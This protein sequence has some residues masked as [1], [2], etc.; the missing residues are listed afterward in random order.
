MKTALFTAFIAL[1]FAQASQAEIRIG[2]DQEYISLM[3][4]PTQV[5]P[6][7]GLSVTVSEGGLA[8]LSKITV[9]RHFLGHSTEEKFYTKRSSPTRMGEATS[10][11][12][13]GI[14]LTVNFTTAPR[15]DGGAYSTLQIKKNGVT[16]MEELSCKTIYHTM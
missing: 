12:A 4:Q 15:K 10:F 9:T 3:C 5:M 8:G 16:S 11:T 2:G 7:N 14:R 6:D 1:A 13:K